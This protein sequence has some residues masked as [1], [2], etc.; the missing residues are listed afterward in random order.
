M[1]FISSPGCPEAVVQ[2]AEMELVLR[3][4]AKSQRPRET[5]ESNKK[6]EEPQTGTRV[7]MQETVPAFSF[8][9]RAL[10]EL[11]AQDLKGEGCTKAASAIQNAT[12]CYCVIYGEKKSPAAQTSPNCFLQGGEPSEEPEAMPPMSGVS[13]TAARPPSR[14]ADGPSAHRVP[15]PL[16]RPPPCLFTPRRPLYASCRTGLWCYS[17]AYT[18]FLYYYFF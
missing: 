10:L 6:E 16:L 12:Q 9:E 1:I 13:E 8:F 5:T 3:A 15:A 11:A 7:R 17:R 4:S 14:V 18:V 2:A